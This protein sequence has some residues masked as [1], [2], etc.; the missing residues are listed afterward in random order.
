MALLTKNRELETPEDNYVG[1]RW[2]YFTLAYRDS[3][4]IEETFAQLGQQDWEY[5]AI[6]QEGATTGYHIFKRAI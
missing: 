1:Q 4:P 5:V 3:K 6:A 2:E